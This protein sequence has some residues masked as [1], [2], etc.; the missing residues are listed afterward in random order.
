M[1]PHR[2]TRAQNGSRRGSGIGYFSYSVIFLFTSHG[3]RGF[4]L[5]TLPCGEASRR[6]FFRSVAS[7]LF[8]HEDH[9]E[10][11]LHFVFDRIDHAAVG[12]AIVLTLDERLP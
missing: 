11:Q 1:E 12:H 4:R 10:L 6:R 5:Q 7:R 9:A 3:D 2:A 8:V